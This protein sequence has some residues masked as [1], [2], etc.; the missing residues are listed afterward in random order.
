MM[1]YS[2]GF[3][4]LQIHEIMSYFNLCE[5]MEMSLIYKLH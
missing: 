1:I 3:Y 4:K 2:E 5:N